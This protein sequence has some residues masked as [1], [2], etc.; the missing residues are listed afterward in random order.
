MTHRRKERGPLLYC[1]PTREAIRTQMRCPVSPVVFWFWTDPASAWDAPSEYD[2]WTHFTETVF[3]NTIE[4]ITRLIEFGVAS[5]DIVRPI[6]DCVLRLFHRLTQP[7]APSPPDEPSSLI[8]L[9][10]AERLVEGAAL[11]KSNQATWPDI[12]VIADDACVA[13]K[14]VLYESGFTAWTL[15][16]LQKITF[17]IDFDPL[18]RYVL[19]STQFID[20]PSFREVSQVLAV[21]HYKYIA[22]DLHKAWKSA[23]SYNVR[24]R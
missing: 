15:K 23:P 9:P 2:M 17:C 14:T 8:G 5:T 10:P 19:L 13:R 4:K 6:P 12:L 24:A 7:P 21:N 20:R 22:N 11:L 18:L 16:T 1:C 3:D